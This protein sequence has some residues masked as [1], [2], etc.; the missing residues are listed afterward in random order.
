MQINICTAISTFQNYWNWYTIDKTELSSN[1]PNTSF[2]SCS[3]FDK[4]FGK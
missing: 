2:L 1:A 3:A 4:G